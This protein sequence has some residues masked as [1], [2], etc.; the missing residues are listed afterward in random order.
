[1]NYAELIKK[2][3][4]KM[5]LS[6]SELGSLLGVSYVTISRWEQGKFEPTIK[7]KKKLHDLF[8]DA[9]IVED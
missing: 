8:V 3:R 2:L 1:M 6:Q 7:C 4:E 9:K 5:F